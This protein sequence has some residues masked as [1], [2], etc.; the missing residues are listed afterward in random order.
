MLGRRGSISAPTDCRCCFAPM[1][2]RGRANPS[3]SPPQPEHSLIAT[4][5]MVA[6]RCLRGRASRRPRRSRWRRARAHCLRPTHLRPTPAAHR[7]LTPRLLTGGDDG[8]AHSRVRRRG[9]GGGGRRRLHRRARAR[10][11]D[12]GSCD[13]EVHTVWVPFSPLL[14]PRLHTSCSH[15]LFTFCSPSVHAFCSR[16]L[17]TLCTLSVHTFC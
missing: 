17:F 5:V 3:T 11:A 15:L 2:L 1:C 9:G 13:P 8:G 7:L 4:S 12:A 6:V 10:S 16:L 14:A